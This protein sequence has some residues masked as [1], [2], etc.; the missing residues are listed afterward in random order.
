MNYEADL[1]CTD[2]PYCV[3]MD[4]AGHFAPMEEPQKFARLI[5]DFIDKD[6][7]GS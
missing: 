1:S 4:G 6:V 5:R 3:S 7:S 2:V